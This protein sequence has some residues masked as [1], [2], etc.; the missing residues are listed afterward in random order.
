MQQ[1]NEQPANRWPIDSTGW[2]HRVQP[3]RFLRSF[4]PRIS[5]VFSLFF[6][7]NQMK[8]LT[9]ERDGQLH[10]TGASL[11]LVPMELKK[12]Y[13]DFVEKLPL[14]SS[15]HKI[16]SSSWFKVMFC[17]RDFSWMNSAWVS[18]K[19]L[20]GS[21]N[22]HFLL[23]KL[24]NLATLPFSLWL[25]VRTE[26]TRSK[27]ERCLLERQQSREWER[28]EHTNLCDLIYSLRIW[29]EMTEKV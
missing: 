6:Q 2:L 16:L 21:L 15:I 4:L 10:L 28:E 3:S 17:D 12:R 18:R 19:A 7:L 13:R 14:L 8:H 11:H 22:F 25:I 26:E 29:V 9:F 24:K 1:K 23:L 20:E 27:K 5:L